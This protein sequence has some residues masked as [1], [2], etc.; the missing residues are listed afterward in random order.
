LRKLFAC[1]YVAVLLCVPAPAQDPAAVQFDFKGAKLGM[2]LDE[3]RAKNHRSVVDGKL[4]INV[5][6]CSDA[7][8]VDFATASLDTDAISALQ[9]MDYWSKEENR[10]WT[11]RSAAGVVD[12]QLFIPFEKNGRYSNT[13]GGS[14]LEFELY[15][16]FDGKLYTIFL[17]FGSA[18]FE[19]V[20]RQLQQ[21]WGSPTTTEQ[22]QF[23]N[24]FGA[25]IAGVTEHWSRGTASITLT[26]FSGTANTSSL[27][28]E[29]Q[30]L[31]NEA[32]K[33]LLK[34]VTPDI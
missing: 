18:D 30:S 7:R 15:R 26:Q 2:S 24:A 19:S 13:V 8:P 6:W 32:I 20:A 31:S 14:R 21:K 11:S 3:F 17:A 12:C 16:F 29:D 5:P 10:A 23:Q 28:F 4:T 22:K 9:A 34:T 27:M 33:R 25:T 1:L